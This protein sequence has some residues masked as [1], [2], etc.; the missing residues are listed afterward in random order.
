MLETEDITSLSANPN[1]F[2]STPAEK[3][4]AAVPEKEWCKCPCYPFMVENCHAGREEEDDWWVE[5]AVF[6]P[7]LDFV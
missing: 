2:P 3:F 6:Q 5:R 1:K 7:R 4:S